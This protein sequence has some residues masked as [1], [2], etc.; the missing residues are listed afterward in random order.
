MIPSWMIEDLE[1]KRRERERRERPQLRIEVPVPTYD[2]RAPT[3]PARSGPIV[4]ELG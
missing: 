3:R 2:E 4:I 1:R